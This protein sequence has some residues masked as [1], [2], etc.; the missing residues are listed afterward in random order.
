VV[1]D[2][3]VLRSVTLMDEICSS[4]MDLPCRETAEFQCCYPVLQSRDC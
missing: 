4:T 3:D 1:S 2:V